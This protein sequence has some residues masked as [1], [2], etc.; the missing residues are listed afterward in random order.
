MVSMPVAMTVAVTVAV[1]VPMAMTVAVAVAV[2]MAE[3]LPCRVLMWQ[4]NQMA[5]AVK[6]RVP[7][8]D[9]A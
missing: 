8:P 1:T 7:S 4:V 5:Y 3:G 9:Q 2:P 6:D